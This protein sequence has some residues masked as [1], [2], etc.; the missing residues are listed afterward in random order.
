M[1]T[2]IALRFP[3]GRV[4][5]TPWDRNVNEGVV[6]WPPSPWRIL[7][8]LYATWRNRCPYLPAQT[9]SATL[10]ALTSAPR[11]RL[12]PEHEVTH[13]RHYLP[14]HSHRPG[15]ATDTTKT[16]DPVVLVAPGAALLVQWPVALGEDERACLS[17]LVD[18]LPYLGRAES[19]VEGAVLD[20]DPGGTWLE[21]L[22]DA[23]ST[24]VQ[25][26]LTPSDP[27]D[28]R[29][30]VMSPLQVRAAGLLQPPATRWVDY[31]VVVAAG[32]D[33]RPRR[34][35]A[36][37]VRP[38]AMR[39]AVTG[40]ARPRLQLAVALGDLLRA[41]A[42]GHFGRT[43]AGAVSAVLSGKDGNGRPL[44]GKHDHAHYLPVAD[45]SG[46]L[47][48]MV[49]WAPRGLDEEEVI[50]VGRCRRLRVGAG[51]N[52]RGLSGREL[53]LGV[54]ATGRIE[55]VAPELVGPAAT[56]VSATP[57]V[58][59]RHHK[60]VTATQL[61]TDVEEELARRDICPPASVE[62]LAGDW[63]SFRRHRL[64]EGLSDRRRAFGLRLCFDTAVR[65]P[66]ALG[67]LSHFGLGLFLPEV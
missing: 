14:G 51:R 35:S 67:R 59:A 54:E 20:D 39:L 27:L 5:A 47:T 21:P 46:R 36:R 8:A 28:L 2:T 31:P 65:G 33:H 37:R 52:V 22:V 60:G 10:A 23:R 12:P 9:V 15:A 55:E 16:L 49:V 4:H 64:D 26:L 45:N 53:H 29:A 57:Y 62:L 24:Q 30:L 38:M 50:A 34:A 61:R 13:S 25:R 6:E 17:E 42:M 43:A 63:S 3:W 44:R 7:R 1:P 48:A 40:P 11:Y 18:E 19:I 66:L 58:M 41:S 32:G 56:W